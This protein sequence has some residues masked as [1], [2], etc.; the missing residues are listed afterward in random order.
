[1]R[2]QIVYTVFLFAS[3]SIFFLSCQKEVNRKQ[4]PQREIA[5]VANNGIQNE[6]KKIYVS[7]IFQLYAAINDPDNAGGTIV[8]APGTYLLSPNYPKGGLLELQYNMSL[9]GQPGH[10]ELVIIDATGLPD[11]SFTIPPSPGNPFTL[12]KGV[13]RMGNG[14][15]AVEWM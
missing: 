1:M 6:A 15:N 12:R 2:K 5:T 3:A 13:V 7:N 8:L 14:R 11:A 9:V 10:P 4:S